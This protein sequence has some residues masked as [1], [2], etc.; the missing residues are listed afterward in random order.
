[1]FNANSLIL[2]F[3]GPDP[4]D[5]TLAAVKRFI[6][7]QRSG[8]GCSSKG[9][10]EMP[11]VKQTARRIFT[12]VPPPSVPASGLEAPSGEVSVSMR[13]LLMVTILSVFADFILDQVMMLLL[14]NL[15]PE[16]SDRAALPVS[17]QTAMF[18]LRG[19]LVRESGLN[20]L[21]PRWLKKKRMDEHLGLLRVSPE[22]NR[23]RMSPVVLSLRSSLPRDHPWGPLLVAAPRL[24]VNGEALIPLM[25]LRERSLV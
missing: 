11:R 16:G 13:R 9:G 8:Q 21:L 4:P 3:P 10:K 7:E 5:L 25:A 19:L 22:E 18:L 12:G 2:N 17:H 6:S 15:L 23:E 24:E 20:V 14:R 1:L